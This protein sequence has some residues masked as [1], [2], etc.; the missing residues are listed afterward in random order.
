MKLKTL[1]KISQGIGL[2]FYPYA[3]VVI[4]NVRKNRI[5]HIENSFSKRKIGDNS[6]LNSKDI[7]PE[8]Y[9]PYGKINIDGKNLKSISIPIS[10]DLDTLLYLLCINIDLTPFEKIQRSFFAFTNFTSEK[11]ESLFK[12]D[13]Q[14]ALLAYIHSYLSYEKL[15]LDYLSSEKRLKLLK[16]LHKQEVFQEKKAAEY[17]AKVLQVSRATIFNDLQK[18]RKGDSSQ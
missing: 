15:T 10:D 8:A 13:W 18:L 1:K 11:P 12:N 16:K 7:A 17:V 3:E 2:I 9:K 5:A 6:F 4:H 14:D